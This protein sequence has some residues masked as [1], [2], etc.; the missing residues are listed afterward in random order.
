MIFRRLSEQEIRGVLLARDSPS[1]LEGGAEGGRLRIVHVADSF[2]TR[3]LVNAEEGHIPF[4]T[5]NAPALIVALMFECFAEV[6]E[7]RS[8][9]SPI[10][11]TDVTL[12]IRRTSTLYT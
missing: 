8:K 11:V 4:L 10:R 7:S 2:K 9:I 1:G 6:R 12:A 3:W 5:E